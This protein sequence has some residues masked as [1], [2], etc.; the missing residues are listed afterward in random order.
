MTNI[1][2][3]GAVLSV[4]TLAA[5]GG[6]T[7]TK[8]DVNAVNPTVPVD[9]WRLVWSDEFDGTAINSDNW[10]HEVNCL[11][12]GNQEKQCYTDTAENSFVSDGMLKIVAKQAAEGAEQPY[13]SARMTTQ[14]KV[15]IQYGRIEMRAKLP[16]GQHFG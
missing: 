5:C 13:T 11:G 4:L 3:F 16:K 1:T 8:T 2:R 15:D 9:D 14:N 6:G 10:T 12:G 7:E